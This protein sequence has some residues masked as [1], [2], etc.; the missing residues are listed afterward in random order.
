MKHTRED[1]HEEFVGRV[2]R[3]GN[4]PP[5]RQARQ[6]YRLSKEADGRREGTGTFPLFGNR[7]QKLYR[8][9]DGEGIFYEPLASYYE[10]LR[11]SSI[12]DLL[13][14]GRAP[15]WALNN[16]T[17][18]VK[19]FAS[20]YGAELG[21]LP[22]PQPG[23]DEQGVHQVVLD[24]GSTRG[25]GLRFRNSWGE[26][27]GDEGGGVFSREY[28]E[29][30]MIEAWLGRLTGVGPTRFTFPLLRRY[31]ANPRAY[32]ET[33][34]SASRSLGG[35]RFGTMERRLRHDGAEHFVRIRETL[36][37][38]DDPVEMIE[39]HG[40]SNVPLGWAHLHHLVGDGSRSSVCQEFFIWPGAR[41]RG[42]GRLLEGLVTERAEKQG[43][44]R[45][46]IPFH[47]ADDHPGGAKAAKPFAK[48]IGYEWSWTFRQ[49]PNVSAVAKK[50]LVE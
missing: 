43:S 13:L 20:V 29:R 15:N 44:E 50:E 28:L 25:G 45:L 35:V 49:K 37:A 38:S 27:W 36:S 5:D 3:L 48:G 26:G 24:G 7:L 42:Y 46:E 10:I 34:V 21:A 4:L 6:S 22:L 30:Y 12:N 23:E 32:A 2:A 17:V 19:L 16:L 1:R 47:E 33:W 39:L 18:S 40:P 11:S 8:L 41:R 9:I 14:R 31:A